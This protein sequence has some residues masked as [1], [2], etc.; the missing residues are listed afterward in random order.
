MIKTYKTLVKGWKYFDIMHKDRKVARIYENGKCTIY[1]SSFL[2][3][4]IYLEN[5]NDIDVKTNNLVNF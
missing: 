5:G 1:Y 4:N 3:Y 2:P